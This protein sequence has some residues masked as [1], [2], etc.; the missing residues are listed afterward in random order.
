L[1]TQLGR[2]YAKSEGR[3]ISTESL[4]SIFA[5]RGMPVTVFRRSRNLPLGTVPS[6]KPRQHSRPSRRKARAIGLCRLQLL[7]TGGDASRHGGM[8]FVIRCEESFDVGL[9]PMHD[10]PPSKTVWSRRQFLASLSLGL[11]ACNQPRERRPNVLLI[12]ADDLGIEALGCYGGTSYRTPHLDALATSGIRFTHAYAQPLCTPTRLQLMT[13]KYNCRNWKAFGVMDPNERTFGHM[14]RD[15]GYRTAIAGKWQFYSYNPPDFE[16]EWRGKGMKAEASGFDEY[17]LWHTGHTEDKGSRYADPVVEQNGELLRDTAGKYGPDIYTDF[18]REF[19]VRK[20]D[21][22]FFAYYPMALTHGP[23]NP[24]PNSQAWGVGDRLAND[25]S[26]FGDMVEY[27]DEL[28]GRLVRAIG[29]AGLQEDTFILFFS[30]NGSPREVASRMGETVVAGGKGLS[31]DAG[32]RVP[33]IVAQPGRVPRATV[34]NDLVDSSD[35]YPT[36]MEIAGLA[37][38]AEGPLDGQSFA[39]QLRGQQG[40]PR[41]WVFFHH[42]PRPGWSKKGFR[43]QRWVQDHRY[44]LYD[45][46]ELFDIEEDVLEKTPLPTEAMPELRS[47]FAAVLA[48]FPN[49]GPNVPDGTPGY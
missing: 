26:H 40:T 43:L 45:T 3:S 37:P 17:C 1:Y 29:E 22:P 34:L 15:A 20:D 47:K 44:K 11:A 2:W 16:P 25:P 30:D 28:V 13:G 5:S 6:P 18:L 48:K 4:S 49:P 38:T 31:T 33:L 36:L 21:R 24:T 19:I 42:D 10:E 41:E 39:P 8:R 12:M 9:T 46:G 35:F 32:T 14:M 7:A 27:M 23:F